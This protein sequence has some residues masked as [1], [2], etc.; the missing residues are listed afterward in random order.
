MQQNIYKNV[1]TH[2]VFPTVEL[3]DGFQNRIYTLF[4]KQHFREEFLDLMPDYICAKL[5]KAVLPNLSVEC[6][7]DNKTFMPNYTGLREAL[8]VLGQCLKNDNYVRLFAT[9]FPTDMSE[10]L[11]NDANNDETWMPSFIKEK[12]LIFADFFGNPKHQYNSSDRKPK[13]MPSIPYKVIVKLVDPLNRSTVVDTMLGDIVSV[14]DDS[15]YIKAD[16]SVVSSK[17][18]N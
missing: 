5:V 3:E 8:Q 17:R 4:S 12:M 16:L 1:R 10:V 6:T 15:I 7:F 11:S 14:E 2:S 13:T 18:F 9:R